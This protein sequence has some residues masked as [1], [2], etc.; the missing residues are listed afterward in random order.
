[1]PFRIEDAA[2]LFE[3]RGDPDAMAYW[4]WPADPTSQQTFAVAQS[5]SADMEAGRAMI[6]TVRLAADLS[7]AGLCDLSELDGSADADLG[8]IFV[9]RLWA[10]GFAREA[11]AAILLAAPS[12]GVGRV[13][14]RVHADNGRSCRLLAGLGFSETAVLEDFEIRPGVRKTCLRFERA[15]A[16]PQ[17]QI[18]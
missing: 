13:H 6:W 18:A 8:F 11:I 14:A 12:L 4:D 2:E 9:R 10:R 5:L 17:P 7:F 16:A 15:L 1:M 3:I